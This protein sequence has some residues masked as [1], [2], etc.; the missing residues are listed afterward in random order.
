M[1]KQ[2]WHP[3]LRQVVLTLSALLIAAC[4]S[5]AYTVD[6][7]TSACR[8]NPAYCAHVAGEET[9]VPTLRGATQETVV[10]TVKGGVEVASVAA[11]LKVL[12]TQ[13]KSS[14][15]EALVKCVEWANDEVNNKRFGGNRPTAAQCQEVLGNDPCGNTVTRAMLLGKQKHRLALQCAELELSKLVPERFSLEQRYR[16]NPQTGQKQLVSGKEAQALLEQG[17]GKELKG[18]IVPDVVIHSGNPLEVLAVYDLKFP[19]PSSNEPSWNEYEEGPPHHG[20][21]QRRIYLKILQ[22]IPK[23][24]APLWKIV[25]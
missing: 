14:I 19:C 13:T 24:V 22:V 25:Q 5:A 12:N 18:T 20:S 6:S 15:E 7:A 21:N 8:Q 3:H 16:D 9:I 17:C 10:S 1:S 11:T 2:D 4:G 23:L